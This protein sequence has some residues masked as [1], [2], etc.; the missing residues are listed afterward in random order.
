M[1]RILSIFIALLLFATSQAQIGR[2]PFAR[3]IPTGGV[4][5]PF[6]KTWT[7]WTSAVAGENLVDGGGAAGY[8]VYSQA[9]NNAKFAI[10]VASGSSQSEI[11][12]ET[13]TTTT[14][15]NW[16][17]PPGKTVTNVELVNYK[18]KLVSNTGLSALTYEMEIT[19]NSAGRITNAS[20]LSIVTD[21]L[22]TDANF[23]TETGS[24]SRTVVAGSQA[25]TSVVR[26]WIRVTETSA[27][28]AGGEIRFDD[29]AIKIT[30]TD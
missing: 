14:W 24:G 4:T 25:S 18:K 30:F 15:E 2:Y 29:V 28:V 3:A 1:K 20:I 17:V 19:G 7:T 6:T 22:G 21:D 9:D 27:S 23:V 5:S 12:R 8:I 16:G 10:A 26:L 11:A 13:A